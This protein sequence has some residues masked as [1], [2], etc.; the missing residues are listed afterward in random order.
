VDDAVRF[1]SSNSPNVARPGRA[2]RQGVPINP[3]G[4]RPVRDDRKIAQDKSAAADAVLGK[5]TTKREQPRRG[6]AIRRQTFTTLAAPNPPASH[7]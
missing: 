1:S 7:P 3:S 6:G 2:V 4:R 5:R